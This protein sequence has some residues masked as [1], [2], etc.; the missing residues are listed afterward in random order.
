MKKLDN[1][2]P[3]DLNDESI[4]E[5]TIWIDMNVIDNKPEN[6]TVDDQML[7]LSL[8]IQ[9]DLIFKRCDE[10]PHDLMGWKQTILKAVT[11]TTDKLESD[12]ILSNFRVKDQ[13]ISFFYGDKQYES[14]GE[15]WG[16]STKDIGIVAVSDEDEFTR[17]PKGKA[18]QEK[19]QMLRIAEDNALIRL[20][21]EQEEEK[22]R[23][24]IERKAKKEVI[25]PFKKYRADAE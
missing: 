12:N 18:D 3:I 21:A 8:K 2:Q 6:W 9:K 5:L 14:Y 15:K 17:T 25:I 22:E 24:E 1:L 23:L 4:K 10:Y 20:K 7:L 19:A 11:D 13:M 16:G